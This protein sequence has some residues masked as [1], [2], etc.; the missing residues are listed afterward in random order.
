[1]TSN[2]LTKLPKWAQQRIVLLER[3]IA[4]LKAQRNAGPET[5]TD[6]YVDHILGDTDAEKYQ[7]LRKGAQV[8]FYPFDG[9]PKYRVGRLTATWSDKRQALE[10]RSSGTGELQIIPDVS[11]AI[12]IREIDR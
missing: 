11:N 3:T 7:P 5:T 4:E 6:T 10:I 2:D 1:M 9:Y 8:V 12:H